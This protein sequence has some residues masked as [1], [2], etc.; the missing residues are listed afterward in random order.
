VIGDLKIFHTFRVNNGFD[1]FGF[2]EK[3]VQDV[4]F[5]KFCVSLLVG[6]VQFQIVWIGLPF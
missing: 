6:E 3:Y 1:G 4:G 2:F 5:V